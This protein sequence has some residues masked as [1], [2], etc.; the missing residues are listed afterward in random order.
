VELLLTLAIAVTSKNVQYQGGYMRVY[1]FCKH[2]DKRKGK[3]T[4]D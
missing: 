4:Y 2:S 1:L 3:S